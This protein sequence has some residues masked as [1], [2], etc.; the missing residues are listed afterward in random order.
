MKKFLL[1]VLVLSIFIPTFVLAEENNI[2]LNEAVSIAE[3]SDLIQD[4]FNIHIS[5][6]PE[7]EI[8]KEI[9]P[10]SSVLFIPAV[11]KEE[12]TV[13]LENLPNKDLYFYIDS[14]ENGLQ[15]SANEAST[16]TFDLNG[17][18]PHLISIKSQHSTKTIRNDAT[19]GDCSAFGTWDQNTLT[20]TMTRDMFEIIEIVN[21]NITLD[22]NGHIVKWNNGWGIGSGIYIAFRKNITVKNLIVEGFDHDFGIFQTTNSRFIN[23][24]TR[25]FG[26]GFYLSFNDFDNLLEGNLV[27]TPS[28]GI[29]IGQNVQR[30]TVRN[31]TISNAYKGVA[32]T[33][34]AY[35]NKV[36]NNNFLSTAIFSL[37]NSGN[38]IYQSMPIGGNY[39]RNYDTPSEGCNDANNDFICDNAISFGNVTDN[40]PWIYKNGWKGERVPDV[41]ACCSNVFFLPGIEASRL[42]TPRADGSEDQLWEPNTNSDVEDLYLNPDGTSINPNIY[43]RDIIKETNVPIPTGSA[44]PNIY[45]S[46]SKM[47]DVLFDDHKIAEWKEFAYDWRQSVDDI[48]NN[49]T[50]YQNGTISLVETLQSLVT[51]SKN[52]KVTIIAHSNGGL[53]AKALLKKLQDDKV[54]GRNNLIDSV[55]VLILVAV[56]EIGTALSVPAIMHGYGQ[57]ILGGWLMTEDRARELGRNMISAYGLLPSKEYIDHVSASPTTFVDNLIPSGVTTKLVQTFGSAISS[58]AEYK[59]FLFGAEGRVDPIPTQ[60]KLP[61][62]LSENLFTQAENLHNNIDNFIPPASLRVIEVAGW[63]LDTVASFEYYPIACTESLGCGY[64]LDE[65]PRKTVDGDK[66]V[67]VP[68][69]QYMSFL[70]SA[71]KYWVDIK[72]YNENNVDLFGKE[73]KN[74][75]EVASLNNLIESVI[76]KKDIVLDTVLK[77]SEPIYTGNLLRVSIHSPVTIDA[78]DADASDP[79]RK[80]TGKICP[81][82]SEFCYVEEN[83]INSSYLEFGEGKYISIPEDQMKSI[84]LQGTDIG[85]F[86]Y[87]SE[88]VLPNGTSTISSF[89]DIPVTTQTQAE[90]TLNQ[91]G[92]PQLALDVT[93]DGVPDFT[94]T[95]SATF[96]P[97]IYLQIMKATIDS[98]D[99]PQ[100]KIKAFDKRVDNIIKSIQKGKINKAQL[101]AEK[102][103]SILEKKLAKPDPKHPKLKRLSK[104]DA[105]LLLDMLNKLLD[106]IN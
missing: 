67:V 83:I 12:I 98:L 78:Y 15:H 63:G 29:Y 73:H 25:G 53:L 40:F 7:V 19:G 23:N 105:Q 75:L 69:T 79:N 58:Y 8:T 5:S 20:C 104:T 97:I 27:D 65:K 30:T 37:Y 47:M 36:Y 33:S 52:G 85:T 56:P 3:N 2:I 77:N 44:G 80:H 17:R 102:F 64:T 43:T 41:P 68:S 24:E 100:A 103:K 66:T 76:N 35:N 92:T 9:L 57:S 1:I 45:K 46:F 89:V 32:L 38:N 54:A 48:V 81:L 62:S 18:E 14:L 74:I 95:P 101:K 55:D 87:E 10:G 72:K 16:I 50:K 21:D 99:L 90:I 4:F 26:L 82:D 71:E 96:D 94:L 84:K 28:T 70:G 106:N 49:G 6:N 86:T 34:T 39:Y 61:I 91:T 51:S 31:N 88:K 42:Y 11:G 59:D 22:G 60:T 93:G 13:L